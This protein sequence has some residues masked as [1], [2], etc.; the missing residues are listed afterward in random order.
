MKA[1][2][3]KMSSKK[4]KMGGNFI[5]PDKELKF[6]G[7]KK[8]KQGGEDEELKAASKEIYQSMTWEMLKN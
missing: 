4:M 6:G 8:Y 5:E 2:G 3:K 1:G 7:I